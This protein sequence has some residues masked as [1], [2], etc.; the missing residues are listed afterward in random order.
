MIEKIITSVLQW[1][2]GRAMEELKNALYYVLSE[3]DI[4]E[5]AR[6]YSVLTEAGRQNLACFLS[7]SG[8]KDAQSGH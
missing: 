2:D 8:W 1:M 7:A 4:S 5:N 3:Y 6:M